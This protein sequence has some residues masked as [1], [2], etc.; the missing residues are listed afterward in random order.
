MDSPEIIAAI[1]DI[2]LAATAVTTATAAVVGL[3]SW[4]R[5]LE[6]RTEFDTAKGLIR[7]TYKLRDELSLYRS[8]LISVN[9]FPEACNNMD[10]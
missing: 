2:L 8:P 3:K 4:R 7:A 1:K 10:K 6:G 5:E 9:E